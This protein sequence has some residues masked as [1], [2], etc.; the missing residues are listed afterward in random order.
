MFC[1]YVLRNL[2]G[3]LYVGSTGDLARRLAEHAEGR[4]RWTAKRGPWQLVHSEEFATRIAAMRREREL[5]CGRANQELRRQVSL[6][7]LSQR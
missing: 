2:K 6:R 5:K 1:V 3:R 7:R 4:A